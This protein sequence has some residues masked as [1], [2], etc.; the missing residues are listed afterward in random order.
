M[1]NEYCF[2]RLSDPSL[3]SE[4]RPSR[5]FGFPAEERRG[6]EGRPPSLVPTWAYFQKILPNLDQ[7]FQIEP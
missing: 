7:K 6:P 1:K 3:N 2:C 4:T 5:R